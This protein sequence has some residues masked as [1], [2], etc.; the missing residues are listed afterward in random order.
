MKET[1]Q[2]TLKRRFGEFHGQQARIARDCNIAQATVNRIARG[3][4]NPRIDNVQRILDWFDR[5]DARRIAEARA[6][7][8]RADAKHSNATASA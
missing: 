3:E 1:I 7:V 5:E 2:Q 4:C 6:L 8:R